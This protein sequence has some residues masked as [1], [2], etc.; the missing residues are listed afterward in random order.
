MLLVASASLADASMPTTVP[1]VAFSSTALAVPSVS[2]TAPTSNSST[3]LMAIAKTWSVNELSDEVA[4]TVMLRLAPSVSRS[5]AP[6]TVTTPVLE[7]IVKR[8]PSSSNS[9]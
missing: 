9:E 1:T 3:S 7:L 4:R 8:P 6:L 2:V 5:I